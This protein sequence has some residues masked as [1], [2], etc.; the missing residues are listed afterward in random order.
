MIAAPA[1]QVAFTNCALFTKCNTMIDGTTIDHAENL[2]L[3]M[4]MNNLIE[5]SSN[6]SKKTGSYGFI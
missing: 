1:T 4:P 3:V 5:Y 6:Y 2:D